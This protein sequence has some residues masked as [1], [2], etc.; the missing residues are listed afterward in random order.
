[1]RKLLIISLLLLVFMAQLGYHGFF[2][3]QQALVREEAAENTEREAASQHLIAISWDDNKNDISWKEE[4]KEFYLENNLYDLAK[5]EVR[6][7]K[8]YLL[9]YNDTKE[10]TILSN[11]AKTIHAGH[12]DTGKSAKHTL[13]FEMPEFLAARINPLKSFSINRE[14]AYPPHSARLNTAP[15]EVLSPP[16]QA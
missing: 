14:L 6:D 8:T 3:W 10:K 12:N 13:K 4:G 5:L 11:I 15:C 2:T 1:M 7:G 16:P 9:C